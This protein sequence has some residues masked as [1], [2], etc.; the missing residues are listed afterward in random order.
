M[1]RAPMP[2][3]PGSQMPLMS[4]AGAGFAGPFAAAGP[5]PPGLFHGRFCANPTVAPSA[6]SAATNTPLMLSSSSLGP[7]GLENQLCADAQKP[8]AQNL[9]RVLPALAVRRVHVD[10]VARVQ[11]VVDIEAGTDAARAAETEH[12]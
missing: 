12:A 8:S 9:N 7:V 6:T 5:C 10:H 3:P 4:R 2:P 11:Q 1:P